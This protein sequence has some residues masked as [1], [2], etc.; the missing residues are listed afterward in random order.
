MNNGYNSWLDI[1][2]METKEKKKGELN[3]TIS[4][5]NDMATVFG[6]LT[7]ADSLEVAALHGKDMAL[8]GSELLPVS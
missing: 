2:A 8:S 3:L 4:Y 5:H 6:P 7:I 1:I